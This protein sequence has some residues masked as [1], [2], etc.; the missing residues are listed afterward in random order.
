MSL[1]IRRNSWHYRLHV[2]IRKLWG[3]PPS[4]FEHWSLCPYFHTNLWG[5]ALTALTIIPAILGWLIAKILRKAYKIG[6]N[7]RGLGWF[8]SLCDGTP[9]G[10]VLDKAPEH[11][12]DSFMLSGIFWLA[13]SIIHVAMIGAALFV[14]GF[15]LMG[16][17]KIL[18]LIPG[19][20]WT[21]I[22][23]VGWAIFHVFEFFGS[24]LHWTAE[25]SV[26]LWHWFGINIPMAFHAVVDFLTSASTWMPILRFLGKAAISIAALASVGLFFFVVANLGFVQRFFAWVEMTANG[27]AEAR[28]KREAER[29]RLEAEEEAKLAE[30]DRLMLEEMRRKM[31]E[32]TYVSPPPSKRAKKFSERA[33]AILDGIT[34]LA[35]LLLVVPVVIWTVISAVWSWTAALYSKEVYKDGVWK[36]EVGPIGVLVKGL[37][38]M[39]KGVC[40]M[41]Q[42]VDESDLSSKPPTKP[43]DGSQP[44]TI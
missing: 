8:N 5:T 6:A 36:E 19:A 41:L 3:W 11:F 38:A 10:G 25:S 23:Y 9:L 1:V 21:G 24:I 30:Q 14:V 39:K 42:F 28:K 34:W 12:K 31:Q 40:P 43:S 4:P 13:F 2:F 15:L 22:L 44:Q 17:W 26:W 37:W 32:G 20:I 18:P 29:R 35:R 7:G 16:G 27:Y 33:S